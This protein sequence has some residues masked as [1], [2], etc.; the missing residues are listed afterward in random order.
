MLEKHT[1][2]QRLPTTQKDA[3]KSKSRRKYATVIVIAVHLCVARG[4]F[5]DCTQRVSMK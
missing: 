1:L 5:C 4:V 3:T 2:Y